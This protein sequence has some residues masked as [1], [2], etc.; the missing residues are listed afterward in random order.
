M[1]RLGQAV[2]TRRELRRTRT[3]INR[4][5]TNAASPAMRDELVVVAQRSHSIGFNG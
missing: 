4:A 5:I 1:S 3:E 2:R